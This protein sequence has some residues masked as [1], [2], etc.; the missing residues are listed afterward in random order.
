MTYDPVKIGEAVLAL[1]G[2]FEFENGRVGKLYD[3]DVMD[4]LHAAGSLSA[5][6]G[7]RESVALTL[8]GMAR[9]KEQATRMF[10]LSAGH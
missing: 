2:A 7:R 6:K 10:A 1:L 4:R 3:F 8:D 5:P 9:A